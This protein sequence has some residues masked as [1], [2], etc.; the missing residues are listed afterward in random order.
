MAREQ[1]IQQIGVGAAA[2][3]IGTAA[4]QAVRT[5]NEKF[6]PRTVPPMRD[7]GKY[8]AD[9]LQDALP[10]E[11][12]SVMGEGVKSAASM[13]LSFGYGSTATALYSAMR[14]EPR[15]L[16]DGAA[17]GLGVWALGYLG[18][19]PALRLAPNVQRQTKSQVAMSIA[20]HVLYGVAS[21]GAYRRLRRSLA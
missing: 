17:L 6:A 19:L 13:L 14:D 21:V 7:P 12:G 5:A 3:L 10:N 16:L 20:Q 1:F 9:R 8:M 15:V 2:G 11:V 18:W 4:M